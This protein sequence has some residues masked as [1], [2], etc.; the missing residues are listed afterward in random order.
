MPTINRITRKTRT[1]RSNGSPIEI[2]NG[3]RCLIPLTLCIVI[4]Q[5]RVMR[6]VDAKCV[7]THFVVKL[8]HCD[9]LQ[10]SLLCVV[11]SSTFDMYLLTGFFVKLCVCFSLNGVVVG[12]YVIFLISSLIFCFSPLFDSPQ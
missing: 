10:A 2:S 8:F 5:D 12:F 4:S 6:C 9:A 3:T 7:L 11:P 1:T